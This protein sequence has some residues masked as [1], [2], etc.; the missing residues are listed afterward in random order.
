MRK[1]KALKK[2]QRG[3]VGGD[4][5]VAAAADVE[6][7]HGELLVLSRFWSGLVLGQALGRV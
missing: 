6:G 4:D 2:K 3:E 5:K 1:L 7:P